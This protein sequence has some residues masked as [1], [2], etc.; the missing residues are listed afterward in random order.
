[1]TQVISTSHPLCNPLPELL[2]RLCVSGGQSKQLTEMAYGW[3]SIICENYSTLQGAED[4]LLLSLEAGFC[5]T[6]PTKRLLE[7]R[8][9]HTDHH[10]KM[11]N[12]VF[13]NGDGEA[14]AD[15]LCAWTSWGDLHESYPQLKMCAEHLICLHHL[16][17]FS[18]RLRSYI[19]YAIE[20]IG[21][22]QF[23]KVE[24][25]G[26]I[27]LL[28]DL[29]VCHKDLNNTQGWA[30]FLLHTVQSSGKIQ[31]LSLSYWEL[32]AELTAYWSGG[33][34]AQAY[35]PQIM[36]SLQ[37]AKEWDK[38]KCWVSIMWL[39]WPPEG[40]KTTEEDFENVMLS[41]FHQQPSILQKLE[42]Q[43][44]QWSNKWL[45]VKIPESFKQI[46]KQVHDKPAQQATL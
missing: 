28:N 38:L 5:Y 31:H 39:V 30:R 45:W 11:A 32:L 20:L 44:E 24:V 18:S 12:I 29:Q 19:I 23:K 27:V 46:I 36:I 42:E 6:N 21:Y 2:E 10:Q 7:A 40:G 4:L 25:E 43:M 14:I 34:E 13:S 41:L 17:P 9:I 26:L 35:N 37:N 3:C 1:M 8:L 16:H 15:L 33:L 22:Q